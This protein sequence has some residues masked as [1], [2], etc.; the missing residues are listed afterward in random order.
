MT[1]VRQYHE[2]PYHRSYYWE[3]NLFDLT[4]VE[5]VLGIKFK[6]EDKFAPLG[7]GNINGSKARQCLH[8][9]NR[10]VEASPSM[11]GVVSGSVVG[12]PQHPFISS[13]CK[14]FNKRCVI[15]VGAKN[16]LEHNYARH[17][18]RLGAEINVSKIGYAKALQKKCVDFKRE[19][20]KRGNHWKMLEL[21]ITVLAK[22]G[23]KKIEAFHRIGAEQVRNIPDDIETLIVPSGSCNSVVSI[24][25]GI[26]LYP[27][28]S[29]KNI[30][31]M[32]I[33]NNGSKNLGYIPERL[34][35]ISLQT[36]KSVNQYF[37]YSELSNNNL[38][39]SFVGKKGRYKIKRYDLNGTGYCK[40]ETLMPFTYGDIVFHPRYEGKIMNYIHE[41]MDEIKKY[42][43]RKTL[44]WIVGGQVS[45]TLA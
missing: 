15:F 20:Q 39:G 3:N 4:P 25:Y 42:W 5:E 29:L 28:K 44:F 32:G 14:H 30:I 17:A 7:Y 26:S 18:Y 9:M 27:P 8:L 13:M 12:S 37:D 19:E 16:Y 23:F 31:L 2:D 22:H 40:Y 10:W 6:R 1:L 38:L 21:N 43:N 36:G 11:E 35:A 24:L 45:D 41:N 34:K 33:G